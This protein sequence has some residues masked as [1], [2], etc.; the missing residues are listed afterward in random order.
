MYTIV[1][2]EKDSSKIKKKL[3]HGCYIRGLY[4][5]GARYNSDKDCLDYQRPKE[6]IEEMPLL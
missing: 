4:L 3:E 6:L 2:K 5:E 1:T